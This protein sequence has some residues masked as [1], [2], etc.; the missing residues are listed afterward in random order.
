MYAGAYVTRRGLTVALATREP[1][2]GGITGD[3]SVSVG[4]RRTSAGVHT[5]NRQGTISPY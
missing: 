4:E 5:A 1:Y 3:A 2:C